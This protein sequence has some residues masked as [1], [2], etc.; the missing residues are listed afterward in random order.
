[1]A[2]GRPRA[3]P[4]SQHRSAGHL[5]LCFPSPL[6]ADTQ[7]TDRLTMATRW[8][9]CGAGKISHDFSVAMRT[10]PPGDHQ[11][12]AIAARSLERAQEFA[13]KHSIPR[14]YGSYEELAAD[15]DI[16]VVYLGV[17]HTEHHHVGLL[18]LK[19]GKNMLCEK[20]FAMN[21]GEVR[22]LVD[23]SRKSNVFLMEVRR[24]LASGAAVGEVK[25][26][27]AYFGSPQLHIPRS[28]ERELGGGALLDIG[29]YCLQ[30]VLMVFD[31][32]RPESIQATGVLL[33]SGVD[34]SMVVVMKFSGNRMAVC[35]F[36]IA[37][38]LPNDATISG[39]KGTIRVLGPMHW[40]TALVVNGEETQYPLPEPCMPLHF[41]NSTGLRYEAEEVRQCLLKGREENNTAYINKPAAAGCFLTNM[42]TRWGIC[43][44]GK[45]SHDF[46]VALKSLPDSDH[47]VVAVAA[48]NLQDA[49]KFA[50][51]HNIPRA[52]GSYEELSGDPGVEVVYVG[53]IHTHH[54]SLSL[55]FMNAKKNV[56]CEKPLAMN[57]REVK[58]MVACARAND[59]FLMEAVWT[60][61]FPAS[62]E[63]KRL[64][65][66]GELGEVKMVRAD[67]GF[68]MLGVP[69]SVTKELGGGALL[70][71]GVYCLQFACMVYGGEKPQSVQVPAHMWSPT[72]LIVNGKET[73]YPVP[74][75]YL[76]L[77]F[78]NSTG[79]RYEA[80]EVRQCLL[81]GLKE[82]PGMSHGDSLLLAE[83]EDEAR[84]QVGVVYSQDHQ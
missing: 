64:V 5:S 7:R 39:T 84:R 6:S 50:E 14:A 68:P 63:I 61:F 43:S 15:P 75:P 33:D 83:L 47:K 26:V 65:A 44:A 45:I 10:L 9:F 29:V 82:S 77:N 60:R 51:K 71:I 38:A 40:P 19:A 49:Q 41:T 11:I 52:Y 57:S 67:F 18:F 4:P 23:A 58:E 34:E 16:D 53:S 24:L 3:I 37:V 1:M 28:V 69:R 66:Q 81:K 12:R 72:S 42:A 46:T 13:N 78:Q 20:P 21:S 70:D 73:Q 80:E 2:V 55:L 56:L 62:L 76:P 17:L 32:E 25:L 59:V 31:G 48:R 36:S 35:T 22:D 30:F 74:E 27:K 8:G 79:M 54:R